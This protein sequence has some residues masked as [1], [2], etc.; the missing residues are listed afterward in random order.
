MAIMHWR[1]Q[2]CSCIATFSSYSRLIL[3]TTHLTKV[4]IAFWLH[5]YYSLL[6]NLVPRQ[7][8]LLKNMG[9]I[10]VYVAVGSNYAQH[11]QTRGHVPWPQLPILILSLVYCT[12]PATGSVNSLV[13]NV[14]IIY[15]TFYVCTKLRM[16]YL[17]NIAATK[18]SRTL[19]TG[20]CACLTLYIRC[21]VSTLPMSPT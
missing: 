21:V 6:T 15:I 19:D 11:S 16:L 3:L 7:L 5:D 1:R 2:L 4:A 13:P 17:Y 20:H 9:W 8:M 18:T 10:H 12:H 14:I